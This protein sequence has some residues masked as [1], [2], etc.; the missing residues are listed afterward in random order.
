MEDHN[1]FQWLQTYLAN[2]EEIMN[3]ELDMKRCLI[4][5]A[6][7]QDGDLSTVKLNKNSKA[8]ALEDI[9]A[10]HERNLE[11]DYQLRAE[12]LKLL[13]RFDGIENRILKEKYINGLSLSEIADIPDI[14]Y[15]YAT[16]KRLHAELKRRLTWLDMWDVHDDP[17]QIN[18]F[19]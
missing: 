18:L 19:E 10:S 17:N 4:E 3:I 2:E 16:I 8:S 1:S 9:I 14:G 6:R 5:L 12:V 11:Q 7:W 15:S 13:D